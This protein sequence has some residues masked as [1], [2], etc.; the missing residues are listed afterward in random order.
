MVKSKDEAILAIESLD[1]SMINT[2]LRLQNKWSKRKA[3][4]IEMWYRRFLSIR[5]KYPGASI[6]PN[7]FID[8]FWH[9]HILNT[10]KYAKD[11][12]KI[13]QFLHH[14]PSYNVE[15]DN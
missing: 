5:I 1:L 15:E 3:D 11:C 13:G 2:K 4:V 6:V 9:E 8:A 12:G 7:E 14:N 10:Q